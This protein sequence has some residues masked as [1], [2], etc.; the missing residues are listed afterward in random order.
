MPQTNKIQRHKTALIKA[1]EQ[2]MGIVTQA[3]KIAKLNR[4]TFYEYY[5]SDPE[6]K[7][8]CDECQDIALDFVESKLIKRIEKGDTTGIIFYLRT[9]GKHRGYMQTNSIVT[10]NSDGVQQPI[11]NLI[12]RE[13]PT[14]DENNPTTD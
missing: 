4:S 5:N 14:E 1:M 9:K 7:K 2:T 3:C 12:L 13:S 6:F 8:A 10:E 11:Y